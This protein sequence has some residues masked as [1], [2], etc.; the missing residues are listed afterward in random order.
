ML[1]G[2]FRNDPYKSVGIAGILL[3]SGFPL[4]LKTGILESRAVKT[5][6]SAG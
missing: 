1:S 6:Q 4:V 3:P 5:D 2:D